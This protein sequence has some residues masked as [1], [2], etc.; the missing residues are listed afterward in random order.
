MDYVAEDVCR[1][2]LSTILL[3]NEP[4]IFNCNAGSVGGKLHRAGGFE[5]SLAAS[6]FFFHM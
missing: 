3:E 1:C 2:N 4:S 5:D 6:V